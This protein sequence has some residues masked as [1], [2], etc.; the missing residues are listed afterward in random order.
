MSTEPCPNVAPVEN[1]LT[2]VTE[3]RTPADNVSVVQVPVVI[4]HGP[5]GSVV[6]HLHPALP[7]GTA[8]HKSLLHLLT[9][10]K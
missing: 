8:T 5:P 7:I 9:I 10:S 6:E 1:R 2:G 3:P 4:A